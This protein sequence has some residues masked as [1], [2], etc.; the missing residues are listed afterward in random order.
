MKKEFS[1]FNNESEHFQPPS[2]N[3]Y[4]TKHTYHNKINDSFDENNSLYYNQDN[5]FNNNS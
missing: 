2:I 1:A 3:I 5:I 4:K